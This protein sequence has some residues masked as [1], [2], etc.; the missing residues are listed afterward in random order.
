MPSIMKKIVI[1][2]LDGFRSMRL[3]KKL[4]LLVAIKFFILFAIVKLLFFPDVMKVKLHNDEARST[5][6]IDQLTRSTQPKEE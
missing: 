6:V 4:W 3:G 1:F 5:Y 2:Y